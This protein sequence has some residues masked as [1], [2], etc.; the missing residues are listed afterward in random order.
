MHIR[1]KQQQQNTKSTT[2]SKRLG[3]GLNYTKT[4]DCALFGVQSHNIQIVP[5]SITLDLQIFDT[6][7]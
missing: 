3:L 2:T 4:K 1:Q 6:N 7:S 5:F